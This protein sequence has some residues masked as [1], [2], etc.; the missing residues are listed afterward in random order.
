[1]PPPFDNQL[2]ICQTKRVNALSMPLEPLRPAD[3]GRV[4]FKW[5]VWKELQY[6]PARGLSI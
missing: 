3:G 4:A 6:P 5:L 2:N 1:M